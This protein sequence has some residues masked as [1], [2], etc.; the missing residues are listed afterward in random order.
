MRLFHSLIRQ[1]TTLMFTVNMAGFLCCHLLLTA[2][3]PGITPRIVVFAL[4]YC[5]GSSV[6]AGIFA[7]GNIK[8]CSFRRYNGILILHLPL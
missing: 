4:F 8:H 5:H 1:I 2:K 7:T 6:S 3:I